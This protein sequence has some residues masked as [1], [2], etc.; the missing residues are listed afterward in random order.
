MR[1]RRR[2]GTGSLVA[3]SDVSKEQSCLFVVLRFSIDKL[4]RLPDGVRPPDHTREHERRQCDVHG[5]F[6]VI[7]PD[8]QVERPALL[9]HCLL[10]GGEVG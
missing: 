8:V 7:Q 6:V 2:A 10:A 3:G 1:S 4:Q 5:T 9:I